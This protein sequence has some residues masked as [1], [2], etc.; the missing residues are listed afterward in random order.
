M[1]R[2]T[3]RLI[4]VYEKEIMSK[5]RNLYLKSSGNSAVLSHLLFRVW[6]KNTWNRISPKELEEQL[7]DDFHETLHDMPEFKAL[8]TLREDW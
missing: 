2:E 8:T 5:A 7:S 6:L 1:D 4:E 3:A